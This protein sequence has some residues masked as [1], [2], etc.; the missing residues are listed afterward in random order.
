MLTCIHLI[1]PPP[2]L[3]LI[4]WWLSAAANF[5]AQNWGEVISCFFFITK[6]IWMRKIYIFPR[7]SLKCSFFVGAAC[8]LHSSPSCLVRLQTRQPAASLPW[9]LQEAEPAM[10]APLHPG[11]NR[12]PPWSG[13]RY[14]CF[15]VADVV[16]SAPATA[17]SGRRERT[18][19]SALWQENKPCTVD[20]PIIQQLR[21][22]RRG[23]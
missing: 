15:R 19:L 17:G 14:V 1:I 11:R 9:A 16:M 12:P 21:H 6:S 5:E 3:L 22:E 7:R 2:P 4:T 20:R 18:E 13:Q 8:D 23:R 10:A